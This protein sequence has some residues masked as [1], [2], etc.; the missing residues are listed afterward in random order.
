MCC[1]SPLCLDY[2]PVDLLKTVFCLHRVCVLSS[3]TTAW[4]KCWTSLFSMLNK[5]IIWVCEMYFF[6]LELSVWIHYSIYSKKLHKLCKVLTSFSCIHIVTGYK[7]DS[8][9][10][11]VVIR[12]QFIITVKNLV[13]IFSLKHIHPIS[14]QVKHHRLQTKRE[15]TE[16]EFVWSIYI[17]CILLW[18]IVMSPTN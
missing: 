13:M 17:L 4:Q 2:L 6:M 10:S 12:F 7:T 16:M 9:S 1:S 8:F 5:C 3:N 15:P 11:S 18:N 14:N